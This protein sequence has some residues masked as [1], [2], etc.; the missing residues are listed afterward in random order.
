MCE[1]NRTLNIAYAVDKVASSLEEKGYLKEAESLDIISNTIEANVAKQRSN[2]IKAKNLTRTIRQLKKALGENPEAKRLLQELSG[3]NGE[4]AFLFLL[5]KLGGAPDRS[6]FNLAKKYAIRLLRND[7]EKDPET[8]VKQAS[9]KLAI[10]KKIV[11]LAV[12]IALAVSID[13]EVNDIENVEYRDLSRLAK[14]LS[15]RST[16][17]KIN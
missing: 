6:D 9:I 13:P 1:S 16:P 4:E 8:M 10:D 5:D 15:A 14:A 7:M 11:T 2:V 12:L 3:K 17:G